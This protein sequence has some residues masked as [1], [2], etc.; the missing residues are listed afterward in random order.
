MPHLPR[1]ARVTRA[2]ALAGLVVA[3]AA[4]VQKPTM[5]LDHAEISGVRVGFPPSL[6]V[7]MNIVVAVD[8]P[9]SY[10][11][12]IRA[13]RGQVVL[14]NM[15][16]LPVNFRAPNNGVWLR[17]GVISRMA[18]PVDIPVQL[19]VQLLQNGMSM[20]T[21]SYRFIGHADVTAT[22]TLQLEKDDYS[23]NE[24]GIMTRQQ[25]A[26]ALGWGF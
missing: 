24:W 6:G 22:S 1:L 19:A 8:N 12:A 18:V 15:Y 11:I 14:A 9:N 26:A 16:T 20:P 5:K 3:S 2:L 17:S 25:L 23:V 4:C 7:L 10:D 21:I 13:V